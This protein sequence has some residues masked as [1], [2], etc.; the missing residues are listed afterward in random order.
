MLKNET[1]HVI[2]SRIFNTD[3]NKGEATVL[4]IILSLGGDQARPWTGT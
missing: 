2:D 1:G 3:L 4:I